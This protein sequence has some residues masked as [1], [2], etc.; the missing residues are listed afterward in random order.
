METHGRG[1][2]ISSWEVGTNWESLQIEDID[3]LRSNLGRRAD[4]KISA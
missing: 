3:I 1:W 4:H 2:K